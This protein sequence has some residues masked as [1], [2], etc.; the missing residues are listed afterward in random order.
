METTNSNSLLQ[1]PGL[2]GANQLFIQSMKCFALNLNPPLILK[3]L[4]PE[5]HCQADDSEHPA[6]NRMSLALSSSTVQGPT[7]PLN[8]TF[9]T[10]WIFN[11]FFS[12]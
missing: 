5:L 9:S 6:L 7:M 8:Q 2:T 10:R 4:D 3:N 12:L 11:G 1:E